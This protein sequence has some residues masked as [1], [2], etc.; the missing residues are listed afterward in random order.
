MNNPICGWEKG[1]AGIKLKG[2]YVIKAFG[3]GPRPACNN[4][5]ARNVSTDN[6]VDSIE[7]MIWEPCERCLQK[8][9]PLAFGRFPMSP[10]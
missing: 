7:E 1:T 3:A 8:I 2:H 9:E 10:G 5:K 6:L 4:S